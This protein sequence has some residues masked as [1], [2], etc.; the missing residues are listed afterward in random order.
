MRKSI[1]IPVLTA[2]LIS[3]NA[4]AEQTDPPPMA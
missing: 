1:V 3:L 2:M 4:C